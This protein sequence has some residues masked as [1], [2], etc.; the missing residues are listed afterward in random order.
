MNQYHVP[1]FHK[2]TGKQRVIIEGTRLHAMVTVYTLYEDGKT[3]QRDMP[4]HEA[5][6]YQS[7]NWYDTA[8]IT[9]HPVKRTNG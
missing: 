6:Q 2:A 3:M 1:T 5:L 9:I 8:A 7:D 4:L